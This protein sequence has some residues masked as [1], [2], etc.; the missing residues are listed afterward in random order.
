MV[1]ERREYLVM[2]AIDDG[3]TIEERRALLKEIKEAYF[4]G[5]LKVKFREREVIYRSR[6]EMLGIIS[7]LENDVTPRRRKNVIL[8][9]F[10]RGR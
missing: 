6:E 5:A 1:W 3:L 2:S 7:D 9:T 8:T 10:S 4:S